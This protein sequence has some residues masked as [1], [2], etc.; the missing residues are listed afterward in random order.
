[1]SRTI[2]FPHIGDYYIV[3][4]YLVKKITKC[5]IIIQVRNIINNEIYRS[6]ICQ[7][8]IEQKNS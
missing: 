5:D 6:I 3:V 4:K 7:T 8:L 1:M 2:S